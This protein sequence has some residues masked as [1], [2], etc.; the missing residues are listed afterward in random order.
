M[1]LVRIWSY[2]SLPINIEK[3]KK[4]SDFRIL[5][6]RHSLTLNILLK[7]VVSVKFS[8]VLR[9]HAQ[10]MKKCKKI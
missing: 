1:I 7:S 3:S 4:Q 9:K 5:T 2:F 10:D 8:G 6:E